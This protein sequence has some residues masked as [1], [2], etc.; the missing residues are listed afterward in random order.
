VLEHVDKQ[1]REDLY[2]L[3]AELLL[4]ELAD[5]EQ[6]AQAPVARDVGPAAT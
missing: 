6:E 2:R 4:A 3:L 1:T 5:Q